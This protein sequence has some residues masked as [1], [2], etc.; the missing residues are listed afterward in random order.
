MAL[1]IF[2]KINDDHSTSCKKSLTYLKQQQKK[3]RNIYL[4]VRYFSQ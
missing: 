3:L 1:F 4:H 2:R